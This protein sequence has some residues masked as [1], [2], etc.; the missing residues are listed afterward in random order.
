[1]TYLQRAQMLGN[2]LVDGTA[3]TD[4][5]LRL[6]R[7]LVLMSD[8]QYDALTVEQKAQIIV[9]RCR[10]WAITSMDGLTQ[11][12]LAAA[13]VATPALPENT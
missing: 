2:A 13:A 4:Q 1:M 11:R 5:L 3:T 9:E 6:S 10:A 8:A 12:E 7:S